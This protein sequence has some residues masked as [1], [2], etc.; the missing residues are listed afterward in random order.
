LASLKE[1]HRHHD[2]NRHGRIMGLQGTLQQ[3]A[4]IVLHPEGMGIL[5][6]MDLF[7]ER[8]SEIRG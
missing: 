7:L 3:I 8:P 1:R 5:E 2:I 6:G 4:K